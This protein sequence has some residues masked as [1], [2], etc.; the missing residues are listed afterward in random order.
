MCAMVL[1]CGKVMEHIW[2]SL[3]LIA[4][5][6]IICGFIFLPEI[7]R[8]GM[9]CDWDGHAGKLLSLKLKIIGKEQ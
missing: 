5:Q 3:A 4:D 1:L 9:K 8:I 6:I 2:T 7:D